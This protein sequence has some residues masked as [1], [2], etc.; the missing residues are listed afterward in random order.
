MDKR[1]N[2]LAGQTRGF[3]ICF[4]EFCF[5]RYI[6]QSGS[7]HHTSVTLGSSLNYFGLEL[8]SKKKIK[9]CNTLLNCD[10]S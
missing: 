3:L 2:L 8:I 4:L 5:V 7:L 10:F 6:P 1:M 9:I